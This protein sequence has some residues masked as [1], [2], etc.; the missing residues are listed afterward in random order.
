MIESEDNIEMDYNVNDSS[1]THS[2]DIW[3]SC[4]NVKGRTRNQNVL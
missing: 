1:C 2:D 4:D 3:L